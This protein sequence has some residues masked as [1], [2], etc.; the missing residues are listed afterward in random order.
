MIAY[1]LETA[2]FALTINQDI[3]YPKLMNKAF[4]QNDS[5]NPLQQIGL[6]ATIPFILA[7]PPIVGWFIGRWLDQYFGSHPY[8]KYIFRLL[9]CV[10]ALREFYRLVMS[11]DNET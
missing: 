8:L 1:C 2:I 10:A 3:L 4:K 5:P 11:L 6:Y 7:V 9:G